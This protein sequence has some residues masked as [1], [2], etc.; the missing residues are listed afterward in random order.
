[1]IV[2]RLAPAK[3]ASP[4]PPGLNIPVPVEKPNGPK[5]RAATKIGIKDVRPQP[6]PANQVSA[7]TPEVVRAGEP[8]VELPLPFDPTYYPA[9]QLDVTPKPLGDPRCPYPDGAGNLLG[10]LV[11][12][13]IFDETGSVTEVSVEQSD[14]PGVF[15]EACVAHYRTLRFTPGMK[16]G[17][18]ARSKSRFELVF[19]GV[20]P[21][22]LPEPEG[23]E[24]TRPRD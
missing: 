4:S 12:Q 10:R 8:A 3:A 17:R 19:G 1:M 11:L 20:E 9:K 14:P 15:D 2:A 22:E 13:A 21:P 6:A 7:A 18:P 23:S 16:D 5:P 24:N